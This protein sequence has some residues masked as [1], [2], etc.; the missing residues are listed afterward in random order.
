V[1]AGRIGTIIGAFFGGLWGVGAARAL[2]GAWSV[3][4]QI[5]AI[6]ITLLIV[7]LAW[8]RGVAAT[9]RRFRGLIYGMAV[10]AEIVAINLAWRYLVARHLQGA[11]L[12]VVGFIVGLHF[13]GLW[14]A[15]GARI[16]L[17]ITVGCCLICILSLVLLPLGIA[18]IVAGFGMAIMLWGS[19]AS[20]IQR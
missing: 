10:V 3:P 13:I 1:N 14:L 5:G 7:G 9:G 6:V 8:S 4:L 15:T 18:A 11:I 16:F 19:T 17:A 20:V 12:P 2:G